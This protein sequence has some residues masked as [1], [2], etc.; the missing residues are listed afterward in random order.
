MAPGIH[1]PKFVIAVKYSPA[2]L[3][4]KPSKAISDKPCEIYR[5]S[6][7]QQILSFHG[8][9]KFISGITDVCS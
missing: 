3:I 5:C 7:G 9:Q 2:S 8:N 6:G 4:Y 1:L